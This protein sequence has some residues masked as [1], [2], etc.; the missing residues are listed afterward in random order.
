MSSSKSSGIDCFCK[1]PAK[2]YST[3]KGNTMVRCGLEL[4]YEKIGKKLKNVKTNKERRRA[5]KKMTLGC[6]MNLKL[7]DA[8][9][10][11]S[12]H[13]WCFKEFPKCAHDLYGKLGMSHSKYN[14]GKAFWAC[15]VQFPDIGCG[16]FKW[17][18]NKDESG[19]ES[20]SESESSSEEEVT[21]SK[22]KRTTKTKSKG[23]RRSNKSSDEE[24]KNSSESESED[25]RPPMKR[26]RR[27]T[28]KSKN[29][30][31]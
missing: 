25:E 15:P 3:K 16:F 19:S 17:A 4:D 20:E 1:K 10:L 7:T 28:R 31:A 2:T 30:K 27:S 24:E 11:N 8:K 18:S 13:D 14:D 21:T 22:S 12:S 29:C 9:Q 5:L 26:R 6:N 23:Q